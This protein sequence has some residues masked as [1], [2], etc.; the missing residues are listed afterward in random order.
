MT[1][2]TQIIFHPLALQGVAIACSKAGGS[3]HFLEGVCLELYQGASGVNG[4]S[5]VATDGHVL[6]AHGVDNEKPIALKVNLPAN[7]V[8]MCKTLYKEHAKQVGRAGA[9]QLRFQLSITSPDVGGDDEGQP[10]QL[11]FG[12]GRSDKEGSFFD[13]RQG[14]TAV[15]PDYNYPDWRRTIS[16]LNDTGATV[17]THRVDVRLL[18]RV[19]KGLS[20]LH[21]ADTGKIY[22]FG[23]TFTPSDDGRGPWRIETEPHIVAVVMPMRP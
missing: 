18:A 23:V 11:H 21:T 12:I 15:A 20:L 14:F 13:A 6:L 2:I 10:A 19:W 9:R 4:F 8:T 5:L 16:L 1:T 3:R 7:A 22:A 17:I